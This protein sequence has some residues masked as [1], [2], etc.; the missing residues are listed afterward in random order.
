M[1]LRADTTNCQFAKRS[2][3]SAAC[4]TP[5]CQSAGFNYRTRFHAGLMLAREKHRVWSILNYESKAV[6]AQF[7]AVNSPRCSIPLQSSIEN[8]S[9]LTL[10]G[11]VEEAFGADAD[12]GTWASS[13]TINFK[14]HTTRRLRQEKRLRDCSLSRSGS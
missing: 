8:I 2:W 6:L 13:G 9:G 7:G 14:L 1:R 5:H 12:S 3:D 10:L 11:A 4:W